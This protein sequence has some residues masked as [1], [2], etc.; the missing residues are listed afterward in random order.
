MI[1]GIMT[2]IKSTLLILILSLSGFWPIISMADDDILKM[3]KPS[4]NF[5]MRENFTNCQ[6]CKTITV[7]VDDTLN[8]AIIKSFTQIAEKL[9]KDHAGAVMSRLKVLENYE[10][11]NGYGCRPLENFNDKFVVYID[12]DELFCGTFPYKNDNHLI[13]ILSIIVTNLDQA[14]R[15]SREKWRH[16]SKRTIDEYAKKYQDIEP[17]KNYFYE[18]IDYISYK[19]EK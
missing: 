16:M 19:L 8:P 9:G 13:S 11:F 2:N 3:T 18:L 17:V 12:R 7:I 4:F 5:F 15:I 14:K 10:V 1:G 6:E